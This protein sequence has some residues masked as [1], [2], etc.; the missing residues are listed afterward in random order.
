M[1]LTDAIYDKDTIYKIKESLHIDY[2]LV[3]QIT[4]TQLRVLKRLYKDIFLNDSHT[5]GDTPNHNYEYKYFNVEVSTYG[6]VW[7][8]CEVGL[9]EDEGTLAQL[10]A[11]TYRLISVGKRGKCTLHNAKGKRKKRIKITGYR[12]CVYYTVA[13]V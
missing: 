2:F 9:K 4:P 13:D 7:V 11:R 3:N 5:I 10:Y 1:A 6:T 8:T 12:K